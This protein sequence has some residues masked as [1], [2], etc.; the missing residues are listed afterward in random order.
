MKIH[1]IDVSHHQGNI[2]WNT[3]C[4]ELKR[5]NNNQNN[6]FTM[7]RAGYSNIKGTGGLIVDGRFHKNIQECNRLGIPCGVY[8]YSYDKSPEAAK[9]TMQDLFQ[10]LRSSSYR[11]EYPVV[12]DVEYET[13]NKTC[14]KARN[15]DIIIAAMKVIESNKYYGM[16]YCSRDFF[17]NFTELSRLSD[18]DKW[19]AAY[20][21]ADTDHIPN[22]IWQ[23]TS[24]NLLKIKGI[25]DEDHL[26]CNV[27]YKDYKDIITK[28][29]LNGLSGRVNFITAGPMT[30][31]QYD[32]LTS[33]LDEFGIEYD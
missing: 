2:D 15:T 28:A 29:G 7:I 11:V 31:S 21:V 3:V 27:S 16:I 17:E 30:Q 12:Y 25:P 24:L 10:V 1:G 18:Y 26:D 6:G 22:G 13:Y 9:K 23:Y 33:K 8:V 19:E 20:T 32:Y 4:N 14:G 5:V